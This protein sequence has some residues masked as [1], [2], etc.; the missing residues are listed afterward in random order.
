LIGT[1]ESRAD[2]REDSDAFSAPLTDRGNITNFDF[3]AK[4]LAD[5][6]PNKRQAPPAA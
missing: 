5:T 1:D 3:V 6:V 4:Q 2:D